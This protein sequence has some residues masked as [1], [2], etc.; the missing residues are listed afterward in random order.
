MGLEIFGDGVAGEILV[1]D[2]RSDGSVILLECTPY[3]KLRPLGS[4][5]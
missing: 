2:Q 3:G 4:Q 1:E 5:V